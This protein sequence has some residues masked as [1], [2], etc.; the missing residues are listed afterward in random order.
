MPFFEEKGHKMP[1]DPNLQPID[2]LRMALEKEK[3]AFAFYS[4]AAE[5]VNNPVTKSTLLEMAEEEKTHIKKIEGV[6]DRYFY[7]DN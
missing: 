3:E 5:K 6:L 1:I 4:E 7:R 2:V